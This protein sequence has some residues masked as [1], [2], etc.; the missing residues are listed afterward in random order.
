MRMLLAFLVMAL[1]VGCA[2]DTQMRQRS[3]DGHPIIVQDKQGTTYVIQHHIGD[4]YTV[5]VIK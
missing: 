4:T 5:Q 3:P 1:A 2:S